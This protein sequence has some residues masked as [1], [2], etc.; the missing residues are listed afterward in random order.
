VFQRIIPGHASGLSAADVAADLRPAELAPADRPYLVL[1]MAATV[2]GRIAVGGKSG[3]VAGEADRQLFHQLR[4]R[5]DAVMAGA[6]T[7]RAERYGRM[8]KNDELRAQREAAG[9]APVPLAVVVS[10]RLDL[11]ADLPLLQDPE[12]TLA[13]VTAVDGSVEGVRA[14]VSYLLQ[15][16]TRELA[17]ALHTLRTSY[18]VRSVLCEGG[19]RLNSA[20]LREGLVDELFFCLAP[21]LTGDS[22]EP[23][24]IEGD[25]LP[26]PVGLDLVSL[27]EADQHLFCRYRVAR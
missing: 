20:L 22:S 23:T 4:A 19:P 18:G 13:V 11:P 7:M 16:A 8:V 14:D 3:G 15:P 26:D 25:A 2:D 24:S 9:L 6:G 17:P 5:A 21:K 10:G 1:N 27:H 12:S